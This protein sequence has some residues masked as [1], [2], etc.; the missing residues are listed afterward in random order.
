M[1]LVYQMSK[2]FWWPFIAS[3]IQVVITNTEKK[4]SPRLGRHM[5]TWFMVEEQD[6]KWNDKKC[7]KLRVFEKLPKLEIDS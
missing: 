2:D 1:E 4:V 7:I 5:S 3:V 6:E